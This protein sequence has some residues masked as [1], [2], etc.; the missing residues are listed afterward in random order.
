[1]A[2]LGGHRTQTLAASATYT[3]GTT[4]ATAVKVDRFRSAT[5]FLDVTA[6]G[7]TATDTLDVYIQKLLPDGST[8]HDFVAFTQVLGNGGAK[9]YVAEWADAPTP[10]AELGAVSTAALSAGV[11]QGGTIGDT[12]RV[13]FKVTETDTATFTASVTATFAEDGGEL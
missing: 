1:M 7:T 13:A 12:L 6:A 11:T 3:V 4:N 9:Q 5:F 2:T 8:Y 10:E